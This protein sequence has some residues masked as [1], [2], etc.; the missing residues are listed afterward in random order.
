MRSPRPRRVMWISGIAWA[1]SWFCLGLEIFY[2]HHVTK[3]LSLNPPKPPPGYPKPQPGQF[4]LT[5]LAGSALAPLI[6]LA[7][8]TARWRDARSPRRRMGMARKPG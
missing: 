4:V 6:F 8:A 1:V 5:V 3:T 2:W 7:A